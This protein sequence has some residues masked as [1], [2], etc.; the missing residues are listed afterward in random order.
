MLRFLEI[1]LAVVGIVGLSVYGWTVTARDWQAAHLVGSFSAAP[2][3]TVARATR[4]AG[5]AP[6]VLANGD[7][8]LTNSA[9]ALIPDRSYWSQKRSKDYSASDAAELPLIGI[10]SIPTLELKTP[11]LKGISDA[12]LDSGVGWLDRTAAPGDVGNAALAGHRDSFFRQLGKLDPGA[13]LVMETQTG[14]HRFRVTGHSIVSPDDVSVL[15]ATPG[16]SEL[17]LITCYP[18]YFVGPAPKRY[19]VHARLEDDNDGAM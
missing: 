4:K 17:T 14:R 10:L 1:V 15:R 18:F 12:A 16:R 9:A 11:V 6:S 5:D 8:H 3:A 2:A 19:I 7:N 13:V